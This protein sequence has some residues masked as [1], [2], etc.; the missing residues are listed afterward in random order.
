MDSLLK[1]LKIL[2]SAIALFRSAPA[3]ARVGLFLFFVAGLADGVLMPFFALWA[4]RDAGVPLAYI[5]DCC[6]HV[7]RAENCSPRHLSVASRTGSVAG[8]FS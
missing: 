2:T 5:L 4:H 7:M 3:P 6:W 1:L 8:R